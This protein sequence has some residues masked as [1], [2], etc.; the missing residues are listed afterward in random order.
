MIILKQLET[1]A[2]TETNVM[3]RLSRAKAILRKEEEKAYELEEN[4]F[5]IENRLKEIV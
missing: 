1:L 2:I 3:P 5:F 4:Y